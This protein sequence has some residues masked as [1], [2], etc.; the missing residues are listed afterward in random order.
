MKRKSGHG[1]RAYGSTSTNSNS[2]G[3]FSSTGDLTLNKLDLLQKLNE[4]KSCIEGYKCAKLQVNPAVPKTTNSNENE[5]KASSKSK[6][7]Q[8]ELKQTQ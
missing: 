5:A 6:E 7:R 1:L 2:P 3:S 8:E 4:M